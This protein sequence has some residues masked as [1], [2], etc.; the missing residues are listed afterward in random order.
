MKECFVVWFDKGTNSTRFYHTASQDQAKDFFEK[1]VINEWARVLIENQSVVMSAP[2]FLSKQVHKVQLKAFELNILKDKPKDIEEEV[3]EA[4]ELDPSKN[5]AL[6]DQF[7][8][9][10][11]LYKPQDKGNLK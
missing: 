9:Y 7:A 5:E 8:T 3:K 1:Q 10:Y 2:A 4:D 6:L 11:F